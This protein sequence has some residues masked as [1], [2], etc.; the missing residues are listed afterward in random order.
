MNRVTSFLTVGLVAILAPLA[1]ANV[2]IS[3]Q[4][5]AVTGNC[6]AGSTTTLSCPVIV[7]GGVTI[8]G[9][10][11]LSNSPGVGN[12]AQE[13]GSTLDISSTAGTPTTSVQIWIASDGFTQPTTPP[14]ILF[15]SSLTVDSTQGTGTGD[16]TSC[17]DTPNVGV[18]FG[19][20]VASPFCA[21]A[22]HYSLVNATEN[23]SGASSNNNTTTTSIASLSSPYTLSQHI[24]V[25]LGAGSSMH[26]NTSDVLTSVPEPGAIVLF[27]TVLVMCASRLR[28]R[29]RV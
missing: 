15:A 11:A 22:T 18:P 24:T 9:L 12:L 2:E 8:T 26:V 20:P 28:R 27:G 23:Y 7:S 10:D 21:G 19:S 4:I 6:G 13:F 29:D 14:N 16:L 3:W 5:G 1:Q 25:S 17:V